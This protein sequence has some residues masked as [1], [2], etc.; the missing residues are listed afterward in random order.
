[1]I[2]NFDAAHRLLDHGKKNLNINYPT[3]QSKM[4]LFFI[5]YDFIPLLMQENYLTAMGDAR[6]PGDIERMAAAADFISIGDCVNN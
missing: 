5:D 1:M 4:D 3:F 2:S 6:G